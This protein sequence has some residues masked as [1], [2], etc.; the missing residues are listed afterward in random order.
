LR[1]LPQ[2]VPTPAP[3]AAPKATPYFAPPDWLFSRLPARTLHLDNIQLSA[4]NET[5][6]PKSSDSAPMQFAIEFIYLK[7]RDTNPAWSHG[8]QFSYTPRADDGVWSGQIYGKL[9]MS[10]W[11]IKAWG[12]ISIANPFVEAYVKKS[13][14]RAGP[15]TIGGAVG[16]ET[17][18]TIR[19]NDDSYQL[20]AYLNVVPLQ[21]DFF[22][23][24]D[25]S[26]ML[27]AA[28]TIGLGFKLTWF[29][30]EWK[31]PAPGST[32]P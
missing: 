2:V 31:G 4:G 27:K 17:D 25:Q 32:P 14:S 30:P 24:D 21:V 18:V 7:K 28:S 3:I 22:N 11:P 12:P 10:D 8:F 1:N 20:Q 5:D 23:I 13:L 16:N 29:T 6:L 9:G 15:W 19:K 26:V